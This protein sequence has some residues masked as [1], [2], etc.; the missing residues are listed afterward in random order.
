MFG[1]LSSV[2]WK[3]N[4]YE[5]TIYHPFYLITKQQLLIKIEWTASDASEESAC[6]IIAKTQL[7][8]F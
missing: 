2:D 5:K 1:S 4:I 6:F 8:S 3:R 7:F